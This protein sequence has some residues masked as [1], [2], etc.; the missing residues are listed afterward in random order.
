MHALHN[1]YL[2]QFVEL[3]RSF[4]V[5]MYGN[6]MANINCIQFFFYIYIIII[7]ILYYIL[8]TYQKV[9]VPNIYYN[10]FLKNL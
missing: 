7:Y 5:K 3:N 4:I 10:I 6:A 2:K 1:Y 8:G 9:L